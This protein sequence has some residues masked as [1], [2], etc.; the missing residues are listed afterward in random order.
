[1]RV[2]ISAHGVTWIINCMHIHQITYIVLYWV[3]GRNLVNAVGRA[4]TG[5]GMLNCTQTRF[6]YILLNQFTEH[7]FQN[8]QKMMENYRMCVCVMFIFV[9]V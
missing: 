4:G 5:L 8:L 7:Q 1:M 6:A 3:A 2:E 9:S